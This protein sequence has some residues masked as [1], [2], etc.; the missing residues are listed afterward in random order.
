M[1]QTKSGR[2]EPHYYSYRLKHK[3]DKLRFAPATVVEAPS[4]YGK[5]TAIRDFLQNSL[6]QGT[7]VYW[8]TAM[9]EKPSA[10][11]RRLRQAMCLRAEDKEVTWLKVK[12]GVT[13]LSLCCYI[14]KSSI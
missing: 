8:F 2:A 9:D 11:F 1:E 5:T 7:P 4:G 3:L 14:I 10:G 13:V 6:P 12:F